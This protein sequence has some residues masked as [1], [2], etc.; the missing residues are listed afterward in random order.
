MGTAQYLAHLVLVVVHL[1]QPVSTEKPFVTLSMIVND[2]KVLSASA[3]ACRPW[4]RRRDG[5]SKNPNT[6]LFGGSLK[7]S[8]TIV[9]CI[10]VC[11]WQVGGWMLWFVFG[12]Q[13]TTLWSCLSVF[14]STLSW[15]PEIK[16]KLGLH[17]KLYMLRHLT[18]T[19]IWILMVSLGYHSI[20]KMG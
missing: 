9:E 7:T 1:L 11:I 2:L 12:G 10:G 3:V 8:F 18:G 5:L 14:L 17:S 6:L 20:V 4:A 19:L 16:L 13:R 15:V